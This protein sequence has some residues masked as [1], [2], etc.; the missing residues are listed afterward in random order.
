[1]KI[2]RQVCEALREAEHKALATHGKHGINVVPVSTIFVENEAIFLVDY[3]FKKTTDNI[4]ER[5]DIALVCWSGTEGYQI[6]GK[7]EY[8]TDGKNFSDINK[9]ISQ[10]HPDRTVSGILRIIPE[11]VYTVG[12]NPQSGACVF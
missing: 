9:R 1:M 2:P 11:H 6:K 4:K 5:S 3:F 8:I 10:I 12:A 7:C